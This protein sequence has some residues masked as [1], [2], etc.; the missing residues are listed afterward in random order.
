[1]TAGMTEWDTK[2]ILITV[3]LSIA[4]RNELNFSSHPFHIQEYKAKKGWCMC[5]CIHH[6]AL[7]AV[8]MDSYG[9]EKTV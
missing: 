4:S 3:F 1:M 6:S 7:P 2:K 9:A 8:E 5:L